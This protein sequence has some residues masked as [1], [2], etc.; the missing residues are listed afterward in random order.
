MAI[1]ETEAKNAKLAETRR[2]V[3]ERALVARRL[4]QAIGTDGDLENTLATI[5]AIQIRREWPDVMT[6]LTGA[7]EQKSEAKFKAVQ[8]KS[9]KIG[10]YKLT[11]EDIEGLT[12]EQIKQLRGY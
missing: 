7:M 6:T 3:D 9:K 2:K 8:E 1:D 11:S 5:K 10:V 12:R 4:V